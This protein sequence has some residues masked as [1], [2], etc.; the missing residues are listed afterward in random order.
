MLRRLV[1]DDTEYEAKA[2]PLLSSL[3]HVQHDRDEKLK[4]FF[5]KAH[6]TNWCVATRYLLAFVSV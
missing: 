5:V 2:H 1:L 6:R 4:P 3:V